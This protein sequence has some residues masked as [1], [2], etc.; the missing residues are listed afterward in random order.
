MFT[1]L[2]QAVGRIEK[3]NPLQVAVGRLSLADVRIGDSICVQGCCLTVV[4]KAK[5]RLWFD[6]SR[7]TLRVT[8]G[9]GLH[10]AARN[11][12]TPSRN[13]RSSRSSSCGEGTARWSE[14]SSSSSR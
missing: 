13:L 4:R 12:G 5:G 9:L 2:V 1:G 8:A 11:A 3:L 14:C 6:V 7:E 10:R